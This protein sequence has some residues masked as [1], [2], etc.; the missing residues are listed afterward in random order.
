MA[1]RVDPSD[2]S[3]RLILLSRGRAAVTVV[4]AYTTTGLVAWYFFAAYIQ[5][6]RGYPDPRGEQLAWLSVVTVALFCARAL[7]GIY[8]RPRSLDA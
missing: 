7:I 6:V 3:A 1:E 8:H 5:T 4:A 2:N